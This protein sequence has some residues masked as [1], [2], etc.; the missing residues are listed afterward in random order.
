M[1]SRKEKEPF[2]FTSEIKVYLSRGKVD[3]EIVLHKN[4]YVLIDRD[5]EELEVEFLPVEMAHIGDSLVEY[6][7]ENGATFWKIEDID[8]E[9]D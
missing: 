8:K 9:E 2:W 7:F 1:S 5:S 4:T 6:D 3:K